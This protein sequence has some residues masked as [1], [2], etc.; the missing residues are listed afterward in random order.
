MHASEASA[1]SSKIHVHVDRCQ[2]IKIGLYILLADRKR[3]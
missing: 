3:W 2:L 1:L